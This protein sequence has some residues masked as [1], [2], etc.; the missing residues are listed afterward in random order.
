MENKN[1]IELSDEDV[2]DLILEEQIARRRNI[3]W[4]VCEIGEGEKKAVAFLPDD[5][6]RISEFNCRIPD[7]DL[8]VFA[9]PLKYIRDPSLAWE[10][11]KK[12]KYSE[13]N[14]TKDTFMSGPIVNNEVQT[15]KGFA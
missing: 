6:Y 13:V 5:A 1:E 8:I 10:F 2:E 3:R 9:Y 15:I 4:F 12:T 7:P 14:T 11:R